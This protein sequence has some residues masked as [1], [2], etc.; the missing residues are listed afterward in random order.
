VIFTMASRDVRP[1]ARPINQF[2]SL[3]RIANRLQAREIIDRLC[4]NVVDHPDTW[5]ETAIQDIATALDI[6]ERR[7]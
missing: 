2:S 5:R 1:R 3:S 6:V 7:Q 4:R